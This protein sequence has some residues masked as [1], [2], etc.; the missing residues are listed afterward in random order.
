MRWV[1]TLRSVL[2]DLENEARVTFA[3][4]KLAVSECGSSMADACPP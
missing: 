4:S 3:L 1:V 2:R